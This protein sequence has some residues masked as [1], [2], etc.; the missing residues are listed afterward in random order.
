M[1]I[2]PDEIVH[3]YWRYPWVFKLNGDLIIHV[4]NRPP[5]RFK[6]ADYVPKAHRTN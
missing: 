3:R 6:E 4:P 2:T 5:I 1:K